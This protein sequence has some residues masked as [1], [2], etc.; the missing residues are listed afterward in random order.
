MK[1][2]CS[3]LILVFGISVLLMGCNKEEVKMPGNSSFKKTGKIEVISVDSPDSVL[4]VIDQKDDVTEFV[5]R[6][7]VN[8][9]SISD[10]PSN[11]TKERIYNMYQGDTVKLEEFKR[12]GK[13]LNLIATITTYK[14]SPYITLKTKKLNFSFKVPNDVAE[15]LSKNNN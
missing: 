9:W 13:E 12:D 7:E 15:Y 10:I 2:M 11:A 3:L 4:N 14:D 5:N 8:K 6:L 1:K